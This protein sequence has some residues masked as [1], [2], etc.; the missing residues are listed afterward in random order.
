MRTEGGRTQVERYRGETVARA[1]ADF[2]RFGMREFVLTGTAARVVDAV[3]RLVEETGV[4]GFNVTPFV[5]PGSYAEFCEEVVPETAP[6][7]AAGADPRPRR[8]GS[9]AAGGDLRSGPQQAARRPPRGPVPPI[10]PRS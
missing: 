3:E 4:D 1:R 6:A 8:P 9:Y 7:R 2:L 5:V 10:P